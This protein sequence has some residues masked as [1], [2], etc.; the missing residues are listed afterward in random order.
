MTGTETGLI[1]LAASAAGIALH[2]CP[3]SSENS[4]SMDPSNSEEEH[5]SYLNFSKNESKGLF[6]QIRAIVL[7]NQTVINRKVKI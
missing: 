2:K 7:Y 5:V 6:L 1:S 3:T 4:V